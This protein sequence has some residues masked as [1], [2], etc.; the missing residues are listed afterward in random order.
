[1]NKAWQCIL[2]NSIIE[3]TCVKWETLHNTWYHNWR[4]EFQYTYSTVMLAD[5]YTTNDIQTK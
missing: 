2:N 4:Y 3:D 1:M 5:V